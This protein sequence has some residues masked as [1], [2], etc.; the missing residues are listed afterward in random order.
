MKKHLELWPPGLCPSHVIPFLVRL[1]EHQTVPA[2]PSNAAFSVV[3]LCLDR[4]CNITFVYN[5]QEVEQEAV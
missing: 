4:K 5:Q 3:L 2:F 1:V